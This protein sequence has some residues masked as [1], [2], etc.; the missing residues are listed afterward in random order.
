MLMFLNWVSLTSI[1]DSHQKGFGLQ[2]RGGSRLVYKREVHSHHFN[3]THYVPVEQGLGK[4]EFVVPG[5]EHDVDHEAIH[6]HMDKE[7]EQVLGEQLDK[8]NPALQ[9][10]IVQLSKTVA[11]LKKKIAEVRGDA[12]PESNKEALLQNDIR[13]LERKLADLRTKKINTANERSPAVPG[14]PKH[15]ASS[16]SP[17]ASNN[18]TAS[19]PSAEDKGIPSKTKQLRGNTPPPPQTTP[20]RPSTTSPSDNSSKGG[21]QPTS[22]RPSADNINPFD[23]KSL[24]PPAVELEKARVFV[25]KQCDASDRVCQVSNKLMKQI[26]HIQYPETCEGKK[27]LHCAFQKGCGF[28]CILHHAAYCM[29]VALAT[30][31]ILVLDGRRFRYG[32]SC[33]VKSS[34]CFFLPSSSCTPY[35]FH[36]DAKKMNGISYEKRDLPDTHVSVGIVEA[37]RLVWARYWVSDEIK[38]ELKGHHLHPDTWLKGH[39]EWFLTR[40]NEHTSAYIEAMRD[41]LDWGHPVVGIHVRRTDKLRSEAK[42][43]PLENYFDVVNQWYANQTLPAGAKRRVYIATDEPQVIQEAHEKYPQ[44]TIL[45]DPNSAATAQTQKTRYGHDSMLALF[46]DLQFLAE[47]DY[48]VGTFSSQISRII[49][50]YYSY[51]VGDATFRVRSMDSVWY[52][53]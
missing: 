50:E 43:T 22:P 8:S 15:T 44:Y 46:A 13:L 29:S 33:E 53:G 20:T 51:Y 23:I 7:M 26:F 18:P 39:I 4:F 52:Y 28:G 41:R 11:D 38:A 27:Y 47:T 10:Q 36:K 17:R 21:Q 16:K 9:Q 14:T 19:R 40:P 45:Y 31:R 6:H 12:A 37:S 35:N 49:Y 42:L 24:P 32:R 48:F 2:F 25:P 5:H 34:D 1:D 30:D 3:G